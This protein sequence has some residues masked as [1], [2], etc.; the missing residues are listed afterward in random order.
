MG[1]T[2]NAEN[3]GRQRTDSPLGDSSKAEP[4]WSAGPEW[5]WG[6]GVKFH[7]GQETPPSQPPQRARAPAG[8]CPQTRVTYTRR[9]E[10]WTR[11]H[12]GHPCPVVAQVEGSAKSQKQREGF[13]PG[14][15]LGARGGAQ[16]LAL[17]SVHSQVLDRL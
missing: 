15:I 16:P 14:V 13:C 5:W 4:G 8:S 10:L 2:R 3:P 7:L 17:L 12:R 1:S 9:R 11:T 6:C